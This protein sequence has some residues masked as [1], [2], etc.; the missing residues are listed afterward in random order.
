MTGVEKTSEKYTIRMEEKNLHPGE[1]VGQNLLSQGYFDEVTI[2]DFPIH[3]KACYLKIK[4]RRWLNEDL[5]KVVSRD[6]ELVA[7]GSRMTKVEKP[8]S[9][10]LILSQERSSNITGLSLTILNV[11]VPMR[12]PSLSTLKL[13]PSEVNFEVSKMLASF[14][15][16][17]LKSMLSTIAP[18]KFR[19]IRKRFENEACFMEACRHREHAFMMCFVISFWYSFINNISRNSA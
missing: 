9:S 18:Q 16:N 19:L 1:F 14:F 17:F 8:S 10:P 6:W 12:Q 11:E 3:G 4:R 7:K 13:K 15:T 2:S 5:G